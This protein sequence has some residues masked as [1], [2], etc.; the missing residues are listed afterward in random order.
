MAILIKSITAVLLA[1]LG[2]SAGL[3][4][5]VILNRIPAQWLCDY[6]EEPTAELLSGKRFD[7]KR[8]GVLLGLFLGVTLAAV[9]LTN[10]ASQLQALGIFM[11]FALM[12]VAASDA[13]YTIIPDQF[14][15]AVAL[16]AINI[17]VIDMYSGQV[18]IKNWYDP[19][20]GALAGG[21][22]L[23]LLDIFSM[24]VLKKEGFGFGDVKLLAAL[25]IMFGW[26][27]T[28]VLLI[29][30]SLVAAVHFLVLI[31]AGNGKI[32]EG[33]YLPMAPYLCLG[34]AVTLIAAPWFRILFL[35]YK[36]VLEMK[37]LP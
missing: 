20:L 12:L 21:G 13:K 22:G 4:G 37:T 14:T 31:F 25:G 29:V 3:L 18:F 11:C 28:V 33:K 35:L 24:L 7:V 2:F 26:K 27:F 23:M 36:S 16:M 19:I 5:C 30:S 17:A 32:D 1:A 10:G 8:S 9:F 34:A 6:D 15:A